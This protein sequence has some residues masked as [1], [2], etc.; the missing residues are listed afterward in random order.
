[1][2]LIPFLLCVE[3]PSRSFE[4]FLECGGL[5]PLSFCVSFAFCTIVVGGAERKKGT[6]KAAS[7]HRTPKKADRPVGNKNRH[8]P[9]AQNWAKTVQIERAT[10]HLFFCHQSFCRTVTVALTS[11]DGDVLDGRVGLDG[12]ETISITSFAGQGKIRFPAPIRRGFAVPRSNGLESRDSPTLHRGLSP[13]WLLGDSCRR[14]R[15]C[16]R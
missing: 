6:A 14:R 16:L 11:D 12:A 10:P 3:P 7:S 4:P 1:M 9:G 5:T 13:G 2:S 8:V 15:S